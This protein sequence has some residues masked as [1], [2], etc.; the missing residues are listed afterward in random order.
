M[1]IF[2]CKR[3]IIRDFQETRSRLLA[4]VGSGAA[5]KFVFSYFALFKS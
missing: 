4:G 3:K 2:E 5:S 1:F